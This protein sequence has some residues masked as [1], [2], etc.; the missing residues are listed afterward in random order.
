[1]NKNKITYSIINDDAAQIVAGHT[2]DNSN[3]HEMVD[4]I[5]ALQEKQYKYII[6]DM[7]SLEFISSAGV[8]SFL[9][10]VESSREIGGDIILFGASDDVKHIFD[11]LDLLDYLVILPD[12]ESANQH[13]KL[14][15]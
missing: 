11:I 7:T 4:M 3:V 5:T 1:M 10:T 2:L 9:G 6:I 15:V 8:G 13:C 12:V 14:N